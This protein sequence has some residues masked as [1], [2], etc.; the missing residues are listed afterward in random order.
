MQIEAPWA[1]RGSHF[2]ALFECVVIDWL[3]DANQSAVGRHLQLNWHEVDGIMSR[4]AKRF[5]R[6]AL[7]LT[8]H[9]FRSATSM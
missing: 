2:T 5:R 3:R 7:E 9:L 6:H 4:A 8:K 1:D